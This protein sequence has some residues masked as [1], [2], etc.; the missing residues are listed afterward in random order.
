MNPTE[1]CGQIYALAVETVDKCGEA[2]S[3]RRFSVDKYV[4][5]VDETA[6]GGRSMQPRGGVYA[7]KSREMRESFTKYRR[8]CLFGNISSVILKIDNMGDL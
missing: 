3:G 5:N 6:V 7:A 8:A 2:R 4:E 1:V